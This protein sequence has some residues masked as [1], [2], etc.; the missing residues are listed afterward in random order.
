MAINLWLQ[1]R[2]AAL[3]GSVRKNDVVAFQ[4]VRGAFS[5]AAAVKYYGRP[6]ELEP[7]RSFDDVFEKVT[8]GEATSGIVPI[9]NSLTGSIHRNYDLLLKYDLWIAGETHVR[10]VHNLIAHP[11]VKIE[12]IKRVYSHPQG[13]SQCEKFLSA[14]PHFEQ[15]SAYD[16]AGSVQLIKKNGWRDAAAIAS[17][18]A[19]EWY[20]MEILRKG[21]EDNVENF[22]RFLV[23]IKN[24]ETPNGADKTSIV[25]STEDIPGALFKSLSVFAL[26]DL[27]L[28]KLESRP[29][30]GKPW[31]YFF[32]LDIEDNIDN[33]RC[34]N[35]INHLRETAN[36]LKILGCYR[37]G[38]EE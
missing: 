21:I 2:G 26:R 36:L 29:L 6:V 34:K 23:L 5:E 31:E 7:C 10:V 11:G 1:I 33:E 3:S 18:R 24:R 17:S 4:G 37:R 13:L 16:T 35:A 22:T 30:H 25:F 9:E 8:G 28:S 19:A 32:Y 12:E 20:E 38:L 15:V 14:Y 27:S